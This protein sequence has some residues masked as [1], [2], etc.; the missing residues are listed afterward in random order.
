M[1]F[2]SQV[3]DS[4]DLSMSS[5]LR[6]LDECGWLKHIKSMMD[7]SIFIA[8]VTQLVFVLLLNSHKICLGLFHVLF[9]ALGC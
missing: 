7:T 1:C 3:F 2:F 4:K 5:Y 9:N 6:G 8:K